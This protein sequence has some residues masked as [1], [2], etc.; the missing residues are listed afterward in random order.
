MAPYFPGGLDD[1][2]ALIILN[3]NGDGFIEAP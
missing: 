3:F 2:V 1:F